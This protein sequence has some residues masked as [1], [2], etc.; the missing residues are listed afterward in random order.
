MLR[1]GVFRHYFTA[2]QVDLDDGLEHRR[3]APGVPG[4]FGID[5]RDR[6]ALADAQAVR[7]GA[8]DAAPFRQTQLLEP[9]LQELPGG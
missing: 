6:A 4:T 1:D 9:A 2:D 8:K 7:L 3:V 5:D